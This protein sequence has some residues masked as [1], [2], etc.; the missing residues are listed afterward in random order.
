MNVYE[1]NYNFSSAI[2]IN[3]IMY[4][5]LDFLNRSECPTYFK[6]LYLITGFV[7][8]LYYFTACYLYV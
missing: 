6:C 4:A 8:F 2:N 1:N 3:K 5:F 7:S